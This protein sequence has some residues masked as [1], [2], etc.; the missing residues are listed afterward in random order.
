MQE[1]A[2]R[3]RRC[4]LAGAG[5]VRGAFGDNIAVDYE[6]GQVALALWRVIVSVARLRFIGAL[7]LPAIRE[8]QNTKVHFYSPFSSKSHAICL[9]FS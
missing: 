1:K 7:P 6:L 2:A 8:V 4:L 3:R 9:E 5:L